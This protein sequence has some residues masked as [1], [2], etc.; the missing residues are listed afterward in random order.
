M[1]DEQTR[2]LTLVEKVYGTLVKDVMVRM[3][4]DPQ[5]KS[6]ANWQILDKARAEVYRGQNEAAVRSMYRPIGNWELDER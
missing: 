6:L 2:Y 5:N 4:D 3:F 1:T